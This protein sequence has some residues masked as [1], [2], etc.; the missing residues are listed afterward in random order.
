MAR[1]ETRGRLDSLR[2]GLALAGAVAGVTTAS[3][4][5]TQSQPPVTVRAQQEREI[6]RLDPASGRGQ[7]IYRS[8]GVIETHTLRV[9]PQG[10]VAFAEGAEEWG[11]PT[12]LTV[13]DGQGAAVH[14]SEGKNVRQLAWAGEHQVAVITG[15]QVEGG[16]GFKPEGVSLIDV[17]TGLEQRVPGIPMPYLLQYV[18]AHGALYVRV[19]A[20][21]E[22]PQVY[23][24][25]LASGQVTPTTHQ[26]AEF[27]PDGEYY[28][29]SDP[30]ADRFRVYRTRDDAD[31]TEQLR[32]PDDLAPGDRGRWSPDAGHA[33]VF[34]KVTYPQASPQDVARGV[35]LVTPAVDAAARG[36]VWV[37]DAESGAVLQTINGR[38]ETHWRTN[39]P[40]L[41]VNRNGR[42][43]LL[44][45][46]G[47][48]GG[49]RAP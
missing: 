40:A 7:P 45:P 38:L 35:A 26:A 1:T 24:Y 5:S 25:D 29:E 22:A 11:A 28:V 49:T 12:S 43:E 10:R 47:E 3:L 17:R 14:R 27:S 13:I 33:L 15:P 20:E 48:R 4:L 19:L 36:R 23:R 31:V 30:G 39:A 46:V 42:V 6:V 34:G 9:G 44:R 8:G 32:L 41:P 2:Y 18:P 21:P 16:I 37:V